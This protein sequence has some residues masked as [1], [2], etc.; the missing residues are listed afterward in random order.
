MVNTYDWDGEAHMSGESMQQ[1]VRFGI[2]TVSSPLEVGAG[3]APVLLDEVQAAFTAGGFK[4][5]EILRSPQRLTDPTSAAQAGRYFY[6]HRVDA[7]CVLAASW[8]EDYL[9]LDMLEECDVPVILYARPGMET[10]SL[11][12]MQQLGFMLKQLGKPYCFVF[13]EVGAPAA[14]QRA[15]QYAAAAA[16]RHQLRRARIG[17]LGHRVQG[18]TETTPH[19]LALKKL[20]GPR[21]VSIDSQVFLERAAKVPESSVENTWEQLKAQVGQ[22][23]ATKEAGID[24]LRVYVTLKD[25]I[26]EL[27][28]AALAVG[29]YPHLMGRV[30]LAASLLGEQG[31]PVSCEGDV[32]G[33]VGMLMLTRLTGQPVHNTDML[34]PIPA[35]NAIV[36][37]HCGSG[38]FSLAANPSAVTLGPVRLMNCGLCC[39]FPARPG[40][41]TLINI[42]PTLN[43]Y[44]MAALYGEATET[45]MVFPG[46]P[47]R[48]RF[49]ADYRQILSWV[50]REGLGHHWMAAYGDSR[51]T[52]ADLAGMTGCEWSIFG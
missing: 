12:G 14:L 15:W 34:D 5:L 50:A 16:L 11:C 25:M 3:Q 49:A 32:N 10:G 22:V 35:E 23:T 18:M 13:D 39:L 29:C 51:Q 9:V 31:V 2:T 1:Q 20:L 4:H 30:C 6:E 28:L 24:S 41:V 27:G 17:W 7:V 26:Q 42:V 45:D 33:A 21:V 48:V 47:L 8:F 38:G 37:T 36:F 19:E 40:P 44:R 46:N 43:S 52:V